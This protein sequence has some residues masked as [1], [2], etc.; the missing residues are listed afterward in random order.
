MSIAPQK[1]T[2]KKPV[3]WMTWSGSFARR[4]RRN[5]LRK[6]ELYGLGDERGRAF[7][8]SWLDAENGASS[9]AEDNGN[10]T[11]AIF[12]SYCFQCREELPKS[13]FRPSCENPEQTAADREKNRPP[14]SYSIASSCY[15]FLRNW[16]SF[17]ADE[18][19]LALGKSYSWRQCL[20]ACGSGQ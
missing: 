7:V 14:H 8:C 12:V 10:S 1:K 2:K 15:I 18:T 3:L 16:I 9:V 5:T 17:N 13:F 19:S 6:R 20:I 11:Y 4:F